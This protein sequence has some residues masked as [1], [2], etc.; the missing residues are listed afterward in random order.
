MEYLNI[1]GH[2]QPFQGKYQALVSK[3]RVKKSII[4]IVIFVSSI[5]DYESKN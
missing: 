5:L 4:S 2:F 1:I 3:I